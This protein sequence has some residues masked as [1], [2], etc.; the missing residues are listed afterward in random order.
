MCGIRC[1]PSLLQLSPWPRTADSAFSF[2]AFRDMFSGVEP[3]S[4][5]QPTTPVRKKA[6]DDSWNEY[7]W[8]VQKGNAEALAKLYDATS[9][10]LYS[11]AL[12][13]LGNAADAEEV[14]LDVYQQI[15]RSAKSFNPAR[16]SVWNWLVLLTRSRALDR[17][18]KTASTRQHELP[19]LPEQ[20]P[21]ASSDPL[22]EQTS[23]LAQEQTTVREAIR[24]L[25][26]EQREALELAFFT[27][28]THNEIA[29]R[30]GLPL[31]TIK[32]RIRS[33][34]DKLRA[35]LQSPAG[36]LSSQ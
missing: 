4:Q 18:R 16:G 27:G 22:P 33:A 35:A 29:V 9:R 2:P 19:A 7:F 21:V 8:E 10:P 30:L 13:V 32:T 3:A 5:P 11:L 26:P 1:D 17:L 36:E 12:R 28:L 23:M 6:G 24:T 14:L 15:W 31:G 20:S 25:P 34:M